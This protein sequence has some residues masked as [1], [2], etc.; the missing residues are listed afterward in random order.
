MGALD[1]KLKSH[2]FTHS[3][4]ATLL[5][6]L[7]QFVHFPKKRELENRLIKNKQCNYTKNLKQNTGQIIE[8]EIFLPETKNPRTEALP[9]MR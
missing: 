2:K 5:S 1:Y 8:N 6:H 4:R 3:R 7:S 9:E